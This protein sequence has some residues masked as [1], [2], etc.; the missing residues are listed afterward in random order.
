MTTARQRALREYP[1]GMVVDGEGVGAPIWGDRGR[2]C[3]LPVHLPDGKT[4]VVTIPASKF[5]RSL[6]QLIAV[7]LPGMMDAPMH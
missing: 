2:W 7:A 3:A 4:L 6:L 1:D 5:Y